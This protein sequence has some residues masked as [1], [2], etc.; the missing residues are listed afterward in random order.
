MTEKIDVSL[1]TK[2]YPIHIGHNLIKNTDVLS[3]YV[4]SK[5]VVIISDSTVADLYLSDVKR[6][7]RDKESHEFIIPPGEGSKS[8][9]SF[10]QIISF[11]LERKIN[12]SATIIALGGGVVGDIAGFVA[13][14]YQRGIKYIQVPTTLLSQVDSSVGGKTAVNHPL[15]KNMIGAFYQPIAVVADTATL[16]TLGERD[17]SAGVAEVVKYGL[18]K[19]YSFLKWINENVSSILSLDKNSL[20]HV[21]KVSC[22]TKAKI[23][24]LDERENG[25]RA[26]LNLGH[27]FGHAI[28]TFKG[29]GSWLHGEAIAAGMV[30]AAQMSVRLGYLDD[31]KLETVVKLL[32]K[33]GLPTEPP[34]AMKPE[35]F[36]DLMSRDKKNLGNNIRLI[37]LKNLGE[38]FITDEYP[39]EI[40]MATLKSHEN[41]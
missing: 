24:E 25:I 20:N 38:A 37:L 19:E 14:S 8:L 9:A 2:T 22:Q 21:I 1:G 18:I 35:D 12:R 23:V 30:M 34:H 11:M 41:R 17:F 36:L 10:E 7:L 4:R 13:A 27:T 31:S 5:Q 6:K 33:C 15:G 16:V 28:E 3:T 29:Y 40:L 26:T 32:K 39:E